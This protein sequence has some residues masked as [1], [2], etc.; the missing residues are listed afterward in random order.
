MAFAL[1][2]SLGTGGRHAAIATR[3]PRHHFCYL[4]AFA[5]SVRSRHS[6]NRERGSTLQQRR[7]CRRPGGSWRGAGSVV[8][9]DSL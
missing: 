6:G 9:P 5:N 7:V 4:Y 2:Y 3:P 8:A 1:Q